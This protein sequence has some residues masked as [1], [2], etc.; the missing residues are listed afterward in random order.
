MRLLGET[1][2][3]SNKGSSGPFSLGKEIMEKVKFIENISYP[4][5]GYIDPYMDEDDLLIHQD[6]GEMLAKYINEVQEEY[7]DTLIQLENIRNWYETADRS[8][9][10]W[11]K[12]NK[13]MENQ[14]E[15]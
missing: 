13:I 5:F 10:S 7:E 8:A 14:N 1:S 9:H 11:A 12:L 4:G 15:S 2:T 3:Y 6:V